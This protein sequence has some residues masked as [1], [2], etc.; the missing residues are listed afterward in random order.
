MKFIKVF[1]FLLFAASGFGADL[2][3]TPNLFLSI[4]K[5]TQKLEIPG[6]PTA[7]NPSIIEVPE[8]YLLTFRHAPDPKKL[9][10]SEVGVV[11]MNH[12]WECISEPQ[13]LST[14]KKGYSTIVPQLED[15]RILECNG[16]L[17]LVY[18]DNID[19]ECPKISGRRDMFLAELVNNNGQYEIVNPIKL[20][21]PNDYPLIT[22]QKNWSPFDYNGQVLFSY[23]I[24]P[25]QVV[26]PDLETGLAPP[27]YSTQF[28][29]KLW[30]FGMIRGGTPALMVDGEYLSFFHSSCK[31][32]SVVSNGAT[33]LHY[34]LGAYT[35][36][37][38]PPF[39]IKRIT[40]LPLIGDNFYT[41][42]EF[43]KRVI[44]PSGYLI[45]DETIYLVYGKEDCELWM[46][47]IDKNDLYNAFVNFK[48]TDE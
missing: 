23:T 19:V 27:L 13:I 14:R 46:C 3:L 24:N 9:W 10:I 30:R 39:R 42:T 38:E 8:G 12:D 31:A 15:A 36:S 33:Q 37:P 18:N 16:K 5:K 11:M 48:E 41:L 44:F 26:V 32:K 21:Q 25:H 28:N 6:Y 45:K 43:P 34:F 20:I 29:T 17:M 47:E 1:F 35:F 22:W 40:P 7:H 4:V 2:K